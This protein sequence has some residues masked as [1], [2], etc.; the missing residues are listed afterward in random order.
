MVKKIKKVTFSCLFVCLYI[1]NRKII[2]PLTL[3]ILTM[4]EDFLEYCIFSF[5]ISSAYALAVC[6][7]VSINFT[8]LYFA[9]SFDIDKLYDSIAYR[10]I[11][12]KEY[13]FSYNMLF[14]SRGI[15]MRENKGV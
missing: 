8:N 9:K 3:K 2:F 4:I 5:F 15:E 13:S 12:V 1:Q 6:F 11:E 14:L 10:V 7:R